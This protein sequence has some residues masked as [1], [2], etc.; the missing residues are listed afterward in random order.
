MRDLDELQ[1][2]TKDFLAVRPRGCY[3]VMELKASFLGI[4]RTE[5]RL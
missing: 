2:K 3:R 4:V 5:V 1:G